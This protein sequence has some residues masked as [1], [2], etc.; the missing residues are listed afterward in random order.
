MIIIG[1]RRIYGLHSKP[2][3]QKFKKKP[4]IVRAFKTSTRL[5]IETP[6]GIM[7]ASEG[8]WVIMGVNGEV[9]P[10]KPDIFKKTYDKVIING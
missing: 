2:R 4:I 7:T 9:Y 6:E 5:E 3:W 10:C 8:D 1:K